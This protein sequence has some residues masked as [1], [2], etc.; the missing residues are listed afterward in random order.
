MTLQIGEDD[1]E[2]VFSAALLYSMFT[3]VAMPHRPPA[4]YF[5][6]DR[7]VDRLL[8]ILDKSCVIGGIVRYML[9]SVFCMLTLVCI[10]VIVKFNYLL[11]LILLSSLDRC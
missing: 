11:N 10:E 2:A 8:N 9:H 4:P 5:Y 6:D 1:S 3:N 7:I